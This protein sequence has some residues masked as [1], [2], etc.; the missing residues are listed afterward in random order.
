LHAVIIDDDDGVRRMLVRFLE[1][2]GWKVS[3]FRDPSQFSCTAL[4]GESCKEAARCCDVIISDKN[5][6][7]VSGMDFFRSLQGK[8]CKC[9]NIAM[10]SGFWTQGELAQ[11]RAW[12]YETIEKPFKITA[13]EAWLENAERESRADSHD[14]RKDKE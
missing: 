13:L 1:K 14:I 11:V 12:G 2:R 7:K 6:P 8:K 5:M 10:L 3:S 9:K 4:K